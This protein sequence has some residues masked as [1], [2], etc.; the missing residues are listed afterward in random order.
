MVFAKIY[1]TPKHKN[2][3]YD[4]LEHFWNLNFMRNY[5]SSGSLYEEKYMYIVLCVPIYDRAL[6]Q[7]KITIACTLYKYM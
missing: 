3:V 2:K 1:N 4:T 5:Y 6:P 7:G